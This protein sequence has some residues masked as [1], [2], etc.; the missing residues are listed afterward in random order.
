VLVTTLDEVAD[1][2]IALARLYR[3]RADAE[4]IYDELK[5]QWG[6]GGFTPDDW[7]PLASWPTASPWATTGGIT[8]RVFTT[9]II[10]TL[11]RLHSIAEQCPFYYVADLC[12]ENRADFNR[13]LAS[14]EG[15]AAVADVPNYA[16]GGATFLCIEVE[17][18]I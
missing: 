11:R 3:E 5:N 15:Q 12:M 18:V 8:T 14:R 10:S 6:R 17:D 4:K 16:T 7:I 2:A 1:P 13:L 9:A